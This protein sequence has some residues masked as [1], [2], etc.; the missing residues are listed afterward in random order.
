MIRS[1]SIALIRALLWCPLVRTPAWS[2]VREMAGT[3]IDCKHMATSGAVIVSPLAVSMSSSRAGGAGETFL[4]SSIRRSVVWPMA[5]TTTTT[6]W[7]LATEATRRL[8][9]LIRAGVA[10]EVPP[11]FW[12]TTAFKGWRSWS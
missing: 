6:G 1:V 12:T 5:E 4:A 11:Y 9:R 10:T 7:A 2:P 3:P 8:T